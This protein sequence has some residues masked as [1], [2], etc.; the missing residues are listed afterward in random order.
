MI[1]IH[2][3]QYNLLLYLFAQK[4]RKTR[5]DYCKYIIIPKFLITKNK[6]NH[7]WFFQVFIHTYGIKCLPCIGFAT[8]SKTT[9]GRSTLPFGFFK[10]KGRKGIGYKVRKAFIKWS[11][12]II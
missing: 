6:E 4:F 2:E 9:N 7:L 12:I 11:N 8:V 5:L 3:T 10:S 1:S